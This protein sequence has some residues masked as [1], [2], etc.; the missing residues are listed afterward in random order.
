MMHYHDLIEC[1][2][3]LYNHSVVECGYVYNLN[4]SVKTDNKQ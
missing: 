3:V 4:I 1:D 2:Q